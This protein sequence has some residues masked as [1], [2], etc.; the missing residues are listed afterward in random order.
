V[1]NPIECLA[2]ING[3][4]NSSGRRFRVIETILYPGGDGEKSRGAR[5]ERDETML[6]WGRRKRSGEKR[7]NKPFKNFSSRGKQRDGAVGG[8]KVRGFSWFENCNNIRGLPDRGELSF[9]EG[10]VEEGG[11]IGDTPRTYVLEMKGCEAIRAHS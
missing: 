3:D 11:K 10:V 1:I 4:H 9:V 6:S 7:K 8:T 2:D 5:T